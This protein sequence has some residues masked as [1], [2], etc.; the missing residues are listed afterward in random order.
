MQVAARLSSAA[1]T[2][3]FIL[4]TGQGSIQRMAKAAKGD[5]P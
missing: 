4:G 3:I 5:C 1:T 2:P